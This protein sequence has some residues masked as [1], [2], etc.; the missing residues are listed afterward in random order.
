MWSAVTTQKCGKLHRIGVNVSAES[1]KGR[2]R[3]VFGVLRGERGK[4]RV[5]GFD[6]LVIK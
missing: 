1:K 4:E 5:W 2:V 3:E 6:E